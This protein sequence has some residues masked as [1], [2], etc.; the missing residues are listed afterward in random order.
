[1]TYVPTIPNPTDLISV[2]QGQLKTNFTVLNTTIS[3]N[4]VAP[5][6]VG[7]GKHNACVFPQRAAGIATDATEGAIYTKD[8]GG[9]PN[10]YWRKKSSGTEIQMTV[11]AVTPVVAANGST[12]LPGGL[13]LQWGSLNAASGESGDITFTPAFSAIPYSINVSAQRTST[14]N[15]TPMFVS[16]T[17]VP[18]AT[19]FRIVNTS[20]NAH[21]AYW[22]AIGLA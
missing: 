22:M 20:S 1:M 21:T 10:L 11:N 16:S 12:F 6:A 15:A 17:T 19:K 2:S 4:H 5:T 8:L 9:S 14:A 3:E 18:T 13:M 7:R